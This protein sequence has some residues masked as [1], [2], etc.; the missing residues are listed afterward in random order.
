VVRLSQHTFWAAD[1]YEFASHIFSTAATRGVTTAR[2]TAMFGGIAV[3][4]IGY[5]K[6][7]LLPSFRMDLAMTFPTKGDEIFFSI[8][9]KPTSRRDVVNFQ[10]NA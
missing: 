7:D 5:V 4:P 9:A 2:R 6:R 10:S 8:V 3:A 1:L